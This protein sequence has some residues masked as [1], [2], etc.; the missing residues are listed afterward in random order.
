MSNTRVPAVLLGK[1]LNTEHNSRRG[2]YGEVTK[3]LVTDRNLDIL[4]TLYK[5][6]GHRVFESWPSVGMYVACKVQNMNHSSRVAIHEAQMLHEL[7]KFDFIPKM[8]MACSV[9]DAHVI[10]MEYIEFEHLFGNV[11]SNQSI[12]PML[13]QQISDL[14]IRLWFAGYAHTDAHYGNFIYSP[15]RK[16][17][18]LIDFGF[19]VRLPPFVVTRA[20]EQYSLGQDALDTW[21]TAIH[22]FV[23]TMD[24]VRRYRNTDDMTRYY[25]DTDSNT[26]NNSEPRIRIPEYQRPSTIA[27][28]E[29]LKGIEQS[30]D[31]LGAAFR[32]CVFFLNALGPW[33]SSFENI[34]PLDQMY[35]KYVPRMTLYTHDPETKSLTCTK[36]VTVHHR[37]TKQTVRL[38]MMH[39]TV[40]LDLVSGMRGSLVSTWTFKRIR[41]HWIL[42]SQP[43]RQRYIMVR[44][45]HR[46]ILYSIDGLKMIH[47][48][49]YGV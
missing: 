38:R 11:L 20:K 4:K 10:V 40:Q 8:Y 22:P 27:N 14:L 18:Y 17:V 1:L 9:G 48:K 24:K 6:G 25:H 3:V 47:H 2:A 26:N 19:M 21:Y 16:K 39:D 43:Q 31:D 34:M 49:R 46:Y 23:Y 29:M 12:R 33:R 44:I 28:G 45:L 35:T 15:T 36:Y 32:Q 5:T 30:K 42:E 13:F 37:R 7:Q 41:A